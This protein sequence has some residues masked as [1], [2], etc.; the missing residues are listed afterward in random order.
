MQVIRIILE[1]INTYQMNGSG[2]YFKEVIHLEIHT[3]DYYPMRGSSYIPLPDWIMRKKAI[4]NIQNTDEKCF[5]WCVLRYLHPKD[6][7]D[8]LLTD[9][10]KYENTINSKG[11]KFPVKI[12]DIS[13]FEK[14][15][16]S[17]PGINVFSVNENKKS[18]PPRMAQ[19]NPQKTIDLFLYEENSKYHYSLIKNFSRLF[20]SQ[21]TS[22]TNGQIY[23]CKKCFTHFSKEQLFQKH[24]SYCSTNETVAVRMP[25][26]NTM[27]CFKNYHKQLPVPFVVYADFECFTKPVNT[28]SPNPEDSYNYNYQKHEPSGFCFYIKGID[29]NTMFKPIIYTKT[30]SDETASVSEIFVSKLAKV[31]NKIYNDFYLRPIPLKLT[32]QEQILFDKAETCHI[33]KTP[34]LADKVRD[35]CHFTD[36]YRGAAHNSCNLQ[37]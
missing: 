34:L 1:K 9:L 14:L 19:R 22:R 5:L 10:K 24:I 26:K 36:Q 25:P 27:L 11:I 16:P 35:H 33:C 29:P 28:C 21:I 18:P 12:K 3:V 17:I 31:T 32:K 37:C 2:W 4:I 23:I 6:K 20:R 8:T 15:N 30:K 7:N 13:K